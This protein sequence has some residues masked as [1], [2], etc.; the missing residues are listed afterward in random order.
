[1]FI[2]HKLAV[3]LN[4]FITQFDS[5]APF[6][7]SL[8]TV[9]ICIIKIIVVMAAE[10]LQLRFE[11]IRYKRLEALLISHDSIDLLN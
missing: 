7:L 3:L 5:C 10:Y 2:D 1:M 8:H 6:L 11:P 9:Q 4:L